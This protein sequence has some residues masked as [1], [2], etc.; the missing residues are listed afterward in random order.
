MHLAGNLLGSTKME[1]LFHRSSNEW[2]VED[3]ELTTKRC[4]VFHQYKYKCF[5]SAYNILNIHMVSEQH[6]KEVLRKN[7]MFSLNF[8]V[9][10]I[11]L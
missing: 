10:V 6:G 7:E 1:L 3:L 8:T 5:H 9:R 4:V 11:M 2:C